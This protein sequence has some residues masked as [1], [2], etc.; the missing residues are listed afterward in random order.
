MANSA[1]GLA[2][3]PSRPNSRSAG[4]GTGSCHHDHAMPT[5]GVTTSGFLASASPTSASARPIPPRSP[6]RP[7]SSSATTASPTETALMITVAIEAGGSPR[8]PNAA[9]NSGMPM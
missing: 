7:E 5:T 9:A 4:S 1:Q 8:S 2:A 6:A 3:A